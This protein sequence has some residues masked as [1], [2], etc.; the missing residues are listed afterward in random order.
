[1]HK[2]A[3]GIECY[4]F[5]YHCWYIR[6]IICS[7]VW[8]LPFK[9]NNTCEYLQKLT[10]LIDQL[11]FVVWCDMQP[12]CY[13]TISSCTLHQKQTWNLAFQEKHM[14]RLLFI[15]QINI[16]L[17]NWGAIWV[18]EILFTSWMDYSIQSMNG[19]N[20]PLMNLLVR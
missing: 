15:N 19:V 9:L 18:L 10:S 3:I 13:F 17:L 16:R 8:Y 5:F 6:L 2:H 20:F 14:A 1:L 11:I 4:Y 12:L 7:P